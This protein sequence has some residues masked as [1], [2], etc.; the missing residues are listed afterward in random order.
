M[1]TLPPLLI[2]TD[3][4][5]TLLNSSHELSPRTLHTLQTAMHHGLRL[6]L[7][8]GRMV[9]SMLPTARIISPNAPMI[10]YNGGVI[11][12][13]QTGRILHADLVSASD[14]RELCALAESLNLHA[15]AYQDGAYF[16]NTDTPQSEAYAA[17]IKLRGHPTNQKLS[18]W[19][20]KGQHKILIIDTPE[21]IQEIKPIFTEKFQGRF[22]CITSKPSYLECTLAGVDK[23][24][25]LK[26][27]CD[28]L[29]I[30]PSDAAAFGDGQNDLSMLKL[31]GRGYVMSNANPSVRVQCALT[32]PSN[33][34]DGVAQII[35]GWFN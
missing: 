15:Q 34:E 29:N 26:T 17:S 28:M 3:M 14:A 19:I 27:V 8:S 21:R 32:A 7:A 1:Y 10:A 24:R 12:D 18:T 33:D 6:I 4:D 25:A 16:F 35:E 5:D 11:C 2:A 30:S 22:D 20:T 23:S 31:V 13:P 9:E